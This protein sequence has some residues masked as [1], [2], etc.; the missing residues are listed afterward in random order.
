MFKLEKSA[1]SVKHAPN[2]LSDNHADLKLINKLQLL[3]YGL[4]KIDVCEYCTFCQ[5]ELFFSYRREKDKTAR[6]SAV[7]VKREK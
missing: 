2:T 1:V 3:A 6:Y 4:Q 7:I 5:S